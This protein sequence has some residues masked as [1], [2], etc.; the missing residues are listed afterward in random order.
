MKRFIK[1]T[2]GWTIVVLLAPITVGIITTV[3]GHY[4]WS[5]IYHRFFWA[6]FI[7][8]CIVAFI[9]VF[10]QIGRLLAYLFND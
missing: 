1:H 3:S 7:E 6:L 2:L 8:S 9:I 4:D 5:A 10:F